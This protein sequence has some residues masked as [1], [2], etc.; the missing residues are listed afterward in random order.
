M[1]K[2]DSRCL[3]RAHW[4]NQSVSSYMIVLDENMVQGFRVADEQLLFLRMVNLG[5]II[6]GY[7]THPKQPMYLHHRA[8]C[9]CDIWWKAQPC[10]VKS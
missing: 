3:K 10:G 9:V 8:I 5:P 1:K 7:R 2:L 6:N 4:M